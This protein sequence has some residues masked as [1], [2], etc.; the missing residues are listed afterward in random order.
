[1]KYNEIYNKNHKYQSNIR[2]MSVMIIILK[3]LVDVQMA[4]FW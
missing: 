4:W 3:L 1:M 2:K